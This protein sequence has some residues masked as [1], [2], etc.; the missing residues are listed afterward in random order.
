MNLMTQELELDSLDQLE[1]TA[2]HVAERGGRI[3]LWIKSL[4]FSPT[5]RL[6]PRRTF[7]SGSSPYI[8]TEALRLPATMA[9]SPR[10]RPRW[11][12]LAICFGV[13]QG[14]DRSN[15]KQSRAHLDIAMWG[16]AHYSQVPRALYGKSGFSRK[17]QGTGPRER[18]ERRLSRQRLS[19]MTWPKRNLAAILQQHGLNNVRSVCT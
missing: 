15:V 9:R 4:S 19:P 12:G 7:K 6:S 13:T 3:G 18:D 2:Q 10:W 1:A 14:C 16:C 5:T 8:L 11:R 17:A